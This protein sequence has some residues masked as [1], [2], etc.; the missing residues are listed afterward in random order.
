M[1]MTNNSRHS[2]M[3]ERIIS[4]AHRHERFGALH[5]TSGH[6]Q[7]GHGGLVIYGALDR[8]GL[9]LDRALNRNVSAPAE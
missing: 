3:P 6:D 7:P 8:L 2:R 9:K 5:Q 1:F 4:A